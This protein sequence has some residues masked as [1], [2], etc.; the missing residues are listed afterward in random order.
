MEIKNEEKISQERVKKEEKVKTIIESLV[1]YNVVLDGKELIVTSKTI[2]TNVVVNTA[3]EYGYIF[4]YMTKDY[5]GKEVFIKSY[6]K[7]LN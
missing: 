7:R 5:E 3:K 6:F 4:E 1:G 2:I